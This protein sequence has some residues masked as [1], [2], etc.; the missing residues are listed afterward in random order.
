MSKKGRRAQGN[1]GLSGSADKRLS[2][3]ADK[4]QLDDLVAKIRTAQGLIGSEEADDAIGT[5]DDKYKALIQAAQAAMAM[6]WAAMK[7]HG[8]R[9]NQ[10]S[11]QMSAQSMTIVLDLVHKA[12]ALGMRRGASG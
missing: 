12:Y 7:S 11:L 8:V 1:K 4:R 3:Q 5:P 6:N 2:K 10:T 9:Q